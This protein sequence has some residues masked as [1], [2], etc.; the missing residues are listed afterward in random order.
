MT[1]SFFLEMGGFRYH[2]ETPDPTISYNA[3]LR[4]SDLMS[5]VQTNK[6]RFPSL[7][8]ADIE[9][10]SKADGMAKGIAILQATWFLTQCIAR[11][12]EKLPVTELEVVT[13]ALSSLS[14]M[15]YLLWWEKPMDVQRAFYITDQG[16]EVGV[17]PLPS[18]EPPKS[19]GASTVCQFF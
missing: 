7:T 8:Q 15:I 11:A 18:T 16:V 19:E 13:L 6:I 17:C 2:R 4:Y 5:L 1:H 12:A 9:D 3:A 14:I 10:K